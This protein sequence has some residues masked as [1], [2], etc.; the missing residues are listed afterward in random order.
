FRGHCGRLQ[1]QSETDHEK[2][3]RLSVISL[4]GNRPVPYVGSASGAGSDPQILLKT[5]KR[6]VVLRT[7]GALPNLC[8]QKTWVRPDVPFS[9][10][11]IMRGTDGEPSKSM[12]P[13]VLGAHR[14]SAPIV[15]SCYAISPR[16]SARS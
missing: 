8:I 5:R 12:S 3:V 9:S 10:E 16:T 1:Q 11:A 2:G 7:D 14:V 6:M 13:T 15:I 4:L